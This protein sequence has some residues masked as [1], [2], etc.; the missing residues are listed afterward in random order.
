MSW[1]DGSSAPAADTQRES[2]C[3][4]FFPPA[5]VTALTSRP[6]MQFA[7]GHGAWMDATHAASLE[8]LHCVKLKIDRGPQP[9]VRYRLVPGVNNDQIEPSAE[10]QTLLPRRKKKPQVTFDS[11]LMAGVANGN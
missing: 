8:H 10:Y 4:L 3:F 1:H 2:K 5:N 6:T 9:G 7:E 11:G